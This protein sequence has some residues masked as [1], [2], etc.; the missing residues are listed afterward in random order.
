MGGNVTIQVI[1]Q[2]PTNLQLQGMYIPGRTEGLASLN[3][4]A[5]TAGEFDGRSQVWRLLLQIFSPPRSG[6]LTIIAHALLCIAH[7]LLHLVAKLLPRALLRIP[8]LLH[9]CDARRKSS[10]MGG[11]HPGTK[12]Q[13]KHNHTTCSNNQTW[14]KITGTTHGVALHY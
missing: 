12:Y 9:A 8:L 13:S 1:T 3:H 14:G 2:Q 4:S 5:N 7:C 10:A 11:K 6:V